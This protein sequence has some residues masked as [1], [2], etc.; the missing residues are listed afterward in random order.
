M[1]LENIADI[2]VGVSAVATSGASLLTTIYDNVNGYEYFNTALETTTMNAGAV[3]SVLDNFYLG[4]FE[5]SVSSPFNGYMFEHLYYD[6]A[7]DSTNRQAVENYLK[8]NG[9]R[10]NAPHLS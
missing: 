2:V 3:W 4:M 9:Q 7:L 10:L 5:D 6:N 8:T 1:T